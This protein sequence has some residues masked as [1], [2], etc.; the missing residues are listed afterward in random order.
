MVL[1]LAGGK[2]WYGKIHDGH[3]FVSRSTFSFTG[4]L[5]AIDFSLWPCSGPGNVKFFSGLITVACA[6]MAAYCS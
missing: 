4:L 5:I 1:H 2:E 6:L 3:G